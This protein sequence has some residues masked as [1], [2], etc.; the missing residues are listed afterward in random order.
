[1]KDYELQRIPNYAREIATAFHQ[2]YEECKIIGENRDL[3]QARL[4]LVL[5]TKIVLKEVLNLMGI[6]APE[7][8]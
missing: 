4:A 5:A 6:S 3:T 2:F 8:M 7:K 1:L